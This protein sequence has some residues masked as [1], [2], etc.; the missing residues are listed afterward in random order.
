MGTHVRIQCRPHRSALD[1][2][3]PRPF[4]VWMTTTQQSVDQ[5]LQHRV[6][7][8]QV[9]RSLTQEFTWVLV[10]INV[11][12]HS[13]CCPATSPFHLAASRADDTN[14]KSRS[15]HASPRRTASE[16]SSTSHP[17]ARPDPVPGEVKESTLSRAKAI[18]CSCL[19]FVFWD[20]ESNVDC[21]RPP[22]RFDFFSKYSSRS[23][24]S[25]MQLKSL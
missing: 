12:K 5:I 21:I 14:R 20:C 24:H 23:V 15:G 18:K 22:R 3:R 1:C 4:V 7:F 2:K 11:A 13:L 19:S 16:M 10:T 8:Q 17:P 25:A 9:S 6:A